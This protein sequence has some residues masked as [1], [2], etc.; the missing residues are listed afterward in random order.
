MTKHSRFFP[1]RARAGSQQQRWFASYLWLSMVF[2][3]NYPPQQQHQPKEPSQRKDNDCVYLCDRRRKNWLKTYVISKRN[4]A[5]FFVCIYLTIWMFFSP[6]SCTQNTINNRNE[7]VIYIV[8]LYSISMQS[9]YYNNNS[10]KIKTVVQFVP[11]SVTKGTVHWF[12][13]KEENNHSIERIKGSI[14][15]ESSIY[16]F[17]FS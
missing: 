13:W 17:F 4:P 3:S 6:F 9:L 14:E 10:N 16:I 8:M 1:F 5:S 7:T 2:Y 11:M 12:Y 15:S